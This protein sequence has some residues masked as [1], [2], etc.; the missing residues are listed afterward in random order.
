MYHLNWDRLGT[1][2]HFMMSTSLAG[3]PE[4][5]VTVTH[6]VVDTSHHRH[7]YTS[8][9]PAHFDRTLSTP[10]E[11]TRIFAWLNDYVDHVNEILA[12]SDVTIECTNKDRSTLS[13]C[14]CL[15][16]WK[17]SLTV[18]V[19]YLIRIHE[20]TRNV[21]DTEVHESLEIGTLRPTIAYIY[22]GHR[23]P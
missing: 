15:H 13:T 11:H 18:C 17:D 22:S 10:T 7:I 19:N 12:C 5:R 9:V 3:A 6:P 8:P 21:W 23:L 20:P 16:A 14:R 1:L 2:D 4:V